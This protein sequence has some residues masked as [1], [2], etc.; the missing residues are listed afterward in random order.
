MVESCGKPR[1]V[2]LFNETKAISDVDSY[3]S[4]YNYQ[5]LVF[6]KFCNLQTD[7]GKDLI[8][9]SKSSKYLRCVKLFSA[10][11]CKELVRNAQREVIAGNEP[12]VPKELPN[13]RKV[14]NNS[15]FL[16]G[17]LLSLNGL[18]KLLKEQLIW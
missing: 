17:I 10:E 18:S 6:C 12:D 2:K 5:V 11:S 3:K 9:L 16:K 13:P 7:P 14:R 8:S 4:S 15:A 1:R